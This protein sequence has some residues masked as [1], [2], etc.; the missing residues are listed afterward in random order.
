MSDTTANEVKPVAA[1]LE[2]ALEHLEDV[3]R[4]TCTVRTPGALYDIDSMALSDYAC[5]LRFLA[6]LGRFEISEQ[7]GRRVIGRFVGRVN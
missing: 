7:Y 5:A 4:Q 6:E 2:E 1:V 3:L